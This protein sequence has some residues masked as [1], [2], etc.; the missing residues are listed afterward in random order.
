MTAKKIT[1][2]DFLA[3][4][5]Y[6]FAGFGLEIILSMILP[7]VLGVESADYTLI[8]H[9]IHWT[10]TC[11]LWGAMTLFL[12]RL[13]KNNY[14]FDIMKYN[15]PIS[16]KRWIISMILVIIAIGITTIVSKGFKPAMEYSGLIKFIFQNIYYL[17]ESGLI[18]LT[19]A[20]GQKFG[21]MITKKENLPWGGLFLAMTWGLVHILL[22]DVNT[23]VYTFIMS[24]LYG[25]VYL[26]LNKNIKYAYIFIAIMFIL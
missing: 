14:A 25:A 8:H 3:L 13:S 20:F 9:C 24:I 19:I 16:K 5:L 18:L 4:G 6:A 17:F 1:A 22:Q 2:T 23:G 21:E 7:G 11:A 10:L 12:L 26:L 15:E